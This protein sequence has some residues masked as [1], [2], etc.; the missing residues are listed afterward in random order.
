MRA[1][2]FVLASLIFVLCHAGTE[3]QNNAKPA[4]NNDAQVNGAERELRRFYEGYAADLRGHR[5]EA[6][7]NRYDSRG[8]F[9]LGNGS[10][11]FVSFEDNKKNYMTR[12]TG[13]K[14][15]EW[16]DLS[17]EVLSPNSASVVGLFDWTNS[18]DETSTG[19]YTAVLTKHSGEWRIRVEDES[20][21]SSGYSIKILSGDP[22]TPGPYRYSVTV[23]PGSSIGAHRHPNDVKITIKSGRM[24]VLMGDLETAKVQ[25]FDAGSTFV[26][27]AKT[28]HVEWWEDPTVAEA[29]TTAPTRTERATPATPRVP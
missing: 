2:T 29:E 11:R 12:W 9:A 20:F 24:F 16:R 8:Y 21:N 4:T 6:I 17:F 19:S 7:A 1:R 5:T 26:I 27:P 13:P 3:A 15:F 28:W 14:N 10:K 18:S 25:R 22:S 23:Q